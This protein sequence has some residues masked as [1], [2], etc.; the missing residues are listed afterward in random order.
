MVTAEEEGERNLQYFQRQKLPWFR[1]FLQERGIQT[2]SERKCKR[3]AD[4]VELAFNAHSVKLAK[5]SEG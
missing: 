5:V 1:T 3:R 4:L 2:S